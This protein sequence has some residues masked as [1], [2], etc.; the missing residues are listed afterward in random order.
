[1]GY[2]IIFHSELL[3]FSNSSNLTKT[4][5]E[6]LCQFVIIK[7]IL[8]L[9]LDFIHYVFFYSFLSQPLFH[10]QYLVYLIRTSLKLIKK[11]VL[12]FFFREPVPKKAFSLFSTFFPK[13]SLFQF[14][15]PKTQQRSCI[16]F[17]MII[18][19][20]VFCVIFWKTRSFIFLSGSPSTPLIWFWVLR[21]TLLFGLKPRI[22]I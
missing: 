4:E 19:V 5:W 8:Y 6:F 22:V 14:S 13:I 17:S 16:F 18:D 21:S 2:C 1:M 11:L 12:T 10:H 9:F 7:N 15:L 20:L 3:L